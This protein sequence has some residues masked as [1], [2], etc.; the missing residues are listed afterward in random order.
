MTIRIG[1][2]QTELKARSSEN[3]ASENNKLDEKPPAAVEKNTDSEDS[4]DSECEG[5]DEGALCE[6]LETRE[7]KLSEKRL[8]VREMIAEISRLENLLQKKRFDLEMAQDD[9]ECAMIDL[10]R[11][12]GNHV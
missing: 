7:K 5:C 12:L 2:K 8:A 6:S 1:V 3:K 9:L 4:E 11:I 10:H